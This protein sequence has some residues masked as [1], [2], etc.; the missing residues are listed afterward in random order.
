MDLVYYAHSKRIYGTDREREELMWL[1]EAFPWVVDPNSDIGEAYIIDP[2]LDAVSK[3]KMVVV[4]E[5]EKHIG[6][7]VYQEIEHAFDKGIQ[8]WV[9]KKQTDG[10]YIYRVADIK[11]VDETDWA[12]RY[13]RVV[14]N[15]ASG[16]KL[17]R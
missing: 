5:Y 10:Y 11:V 4:S 14:V 1:R 12:I 8:V 7:G 17:I 16:K 9:L 3:C 15:S 13:G 6:K 2:Y